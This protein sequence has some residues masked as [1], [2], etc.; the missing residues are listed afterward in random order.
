MTTYKQLTDDQR[1]PIDAL[2]KTG[3]PQSS[4]AELLEVTQPTISQE[5]KRNT[6][7]KRYRYY[8][9]QRLTDQQRSQPLNH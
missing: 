7:L 1:C 5:L 6:E 2:K 9:A 3:I 8:Q 4:I